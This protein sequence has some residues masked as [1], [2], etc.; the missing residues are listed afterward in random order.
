MRKTIEPISRMKTYIFCPIAHGHRNARMI[1]YGIDKQVNPNIKSA[2]T[3]T[4][5]FECRNWFEWIHKEEYK[6]NS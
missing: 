1:R 4:V 6:Y 5:L 3:I 2:C